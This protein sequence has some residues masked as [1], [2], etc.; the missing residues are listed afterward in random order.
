MRLSNNKVSVLLA[1]TAIALAACGQPNPTQDDVIIPDVVAEDTFVQTQDVSVETSVDSGIEVDSS[2]DSSDAA[3]QN[4]EDVSGE[5]AS[6]IQRDSEVQD[7]SSI[8][9]VATY[10]RSERVL[11]IISGD[12]ISNTIT[13]GLPVPCAREVPVTESANCKVYRFFADVEEYRRSRADSGLANITMM[14]N[15]TTRIVIPKSRITSSSLELAPPHHFIGT[16]EFPVDLSGIDA[17]SYSLNIE[18]ASMNHRIQIAN[19]QIM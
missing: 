1:L 11:R 17:G 16:I 14:V 18:S 9:V 8:Y 12:S 19:V 6:V 13:L 7:A 3:I 4:Q 5:D 15:I 10:S 2:T